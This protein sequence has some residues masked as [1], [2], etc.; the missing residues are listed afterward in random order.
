MKCQNCGTDNLN[1]AKFCAKCGVGLEAQPMHA[2]GANPNV[3][4]NVN[5][6][7]ST[8]SS[9][10]FKNI[11][12][13]ILNAIVKPSKAFND[14]KDKDYK[15][16]A[17]YGGIFIGLITVL[18]IILYL[19]YGLVGGKFKDTYYAQ[20]DFGTICKEFFYCFITHIQFNKEP[21]FKHSS[22]SS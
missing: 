11:F 3:G 14:L 9:F 5:T 19:I 1:G 13:T 22:S 17:I 15:G 16:I 10:N 2:E 18:H 6:H 20:W 4:A 12:K 7:S 21:F 8:K